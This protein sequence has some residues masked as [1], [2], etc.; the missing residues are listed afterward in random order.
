MTAMVVA[1]AICAAKQA[2][3]WKNSETL[4]THALACTTRNDVAEFNLGN[5]FRLEGK[6]DDAIAHY[7]N[8][9][10]IRPNYAQAHVN[11]GHALLDKGQVD[12][13]IAHFESALQTKPRD[14][15]A[16]FNL[17]NAFREQGKL[18]DA[19][20]QYQMV[21]QL[22]PNFAN[23]HV[24]L[25]K[26]LFQQGKVMESIAEY[27][28]ALELTPNN[29]EANFDLGVALLQERRPDEAIPHFQR[30]LAFRPGSALAHGYLGNA[31]RQEGRVADA[32][33]QFE[34]A[35][36]IEPANPAIANNLAW[37]LATDPDA[38][39]RNG[40]KAVELAERA[41][42]NSHG[43]NPFVLCTL[44][45][46]YAEAGRFSDAV[47]AAQHA[48]QLAGAGSNTALASQIE[49]E[50]KLYRAGRPYHLGEAQETA[51]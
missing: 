22:K 36:Q 33:A 18:D 39:V 30:S 9:L 31:Y 50:L 5:A 47:Q 13:A 4:W 19:I 8:A 2:A 24:N 32:A 20:A 41:N 34:E 7:E 44:A 28:S 43:G 25:G 15:T 38:S 14:A 51:K 45:A 21:L 10:K 35:L 3:Y 49:S 27:Q 17:G 46:A 29:A 11:L 1:L 26:I 12:D 6:M 23:A 48:L 16:H 40:A 42:Q 37:L